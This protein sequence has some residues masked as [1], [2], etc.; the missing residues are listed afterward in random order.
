MDR[1]PYLTFF[2]IK[3]SCTTFSLPSFHLQAICLRYDGEKGNMLEEHPGIDDNSILRS[4]CLL[5]NSASLHI[6]S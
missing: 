1:S 6:V 4:F 3:K 5:N 2:S